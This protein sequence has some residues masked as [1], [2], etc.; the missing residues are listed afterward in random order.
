MVISKPV[1]GGISGEWMVILARRFNYPDGTF[2]GLVYAGL[3]LKQL[4]QSFRKL[5]VGT[6]GTITLIDD[7]LSFVTRYPELKVVGAEIAQEVGSPQ[8]LDLIRAGKTAATYMAT[9]SIDGLER[10]YSY[11]RLSHGG[12][13]YIITGLSKGDYLANWH[14]V[15][16]K[17]LMFSALFFIITV[18][19]TW[20]FC[21]ESN[22][23]R[24]AEQKALKNELRFR[25]F[26]ENANDLIY[27]LSSRGI[28]TYVA[29]NVKFLLGYLPG[30]LIGTS[31]ELLV[32]QKE[33]SSCK[34]FLRT[35]MESGIKVENLRS[36]TIQQRF[37]NTM[38]SILMWQHLK[39]ILNYGRS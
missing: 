25:T 21:R 20:L 13:F 23:T 27:T 12:Q 38:R 18:V 6:D 31:F 16:Q 3:G 37:V 29:P 28:I 15:V 32:H 30:E 14:T 5:N 7:D 39:P 19:F 9:S 36:P 17:M 11:S 8:F 26:I 1:I 34:T 4:S 35:I 10:I 24:K 2:A 33:L 22:S